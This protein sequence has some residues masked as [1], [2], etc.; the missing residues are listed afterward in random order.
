MILIKINYIIKLIFQKKKEKVLQFTQLTLIFNFI[1]VKFQILKYIKINLLT[2]RMY[3]FS[4]TII[5]NINVSY[6]DISL[7]IIINKFNILSLKQ[8]FTNK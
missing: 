6:L 2:N 5:C 1:K 3:I 4:S 8:A 7:S